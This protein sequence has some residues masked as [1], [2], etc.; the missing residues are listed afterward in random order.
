MLVKPGE[1]SVTFF[2]IFRSLTVL[3]NQDDTNFK[4]DDLVGLIPSG[5]AAKHNSLG[6]TS[7]PRGNIACNLK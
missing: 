3:C 7:L 2:I 1:A 5:A 4:I 6:K